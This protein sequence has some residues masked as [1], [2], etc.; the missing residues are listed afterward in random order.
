ML[1]LAGMWVSGC[2]SLGG[3]SLVG[4]V[5]AL[6]VA[7]AL[8]SAALLLEACVYLVEDVVDVRA[9]MASENE[10]AIEFND[11]TTWDGKIQ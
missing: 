9:K 1:V 5:C 7:T 4:H 11:E 6:S 2:P 8:S 10:L 3:F